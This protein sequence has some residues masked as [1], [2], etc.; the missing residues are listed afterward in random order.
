M[1][2]YSFL[3][4]VIN[5]LLN[6]GASSVFYIICHGPLV[7]LWQIWGLIWDLNLEPLQKCWQMNVRYVLFSVKPK[8]TR[9][10]ASQTN[11]M[12][13]PV[14][15]SQVQILDEPP[16]LSQLVKCHDK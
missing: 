3:L 5:I 4:N 7:V 16:N 15:R 12:M 6:S 13:P 2:Y 11:N 1:E 14:Q 9:P 10:K 8:A